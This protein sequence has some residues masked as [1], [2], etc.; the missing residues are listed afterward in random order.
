MFL[1]SIPGSLVGFELL[2]EE[3][4]D[5]HLIAKLSKSKQMDDNAALAFPASKTDTTFR[6]YQK[7]LKNLSIEVKNHFYS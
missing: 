7:S 6:F 3:V 5:N 4:L 2:M 1:F